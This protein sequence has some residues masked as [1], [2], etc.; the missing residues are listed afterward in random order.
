MLLALLVGHAL[1]SAQ[2]IAEAVGLVEKAQTATVTVAKLSEE[3]SSAP[4][5]TRYWF[6]KGGFYRTESPQGTLICNPKQSWAYL[7]KGTGYKMYPGA[8]T[9]WSLGRELG[10]L[11]LGRFPPIGSP[12]SVSWHGHPTL[13]V[14]LDGRSLTKETKMFCFFD[15]VSHFPLGISANLGSVTQVRVFENLK[16]NPK[17]DPAMFT[18]V[19]PKGWKLVKD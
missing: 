7:P 11:D 13:R 10:I 16:L 3:F 17:I 19:P 8:P 15:P 9:D 1:T 6:R 2:L 14:E 12:K 5:K 4:Y 18:F